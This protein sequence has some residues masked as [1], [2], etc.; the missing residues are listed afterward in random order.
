MSKL[1]IV[2]P[3]F[4]AVG[5]PAQS[6]LNTANALKDAIHISYLVSAQTGYSEDPLNT[7]RQTAKQ[8]ETFKVNSASLRE[9]TL[10]A[11]FALCKLK[12]RSHNFTHVFFFDAH[13]VL[14][15]ALWFLFY[16]LLKP[17]RLSLIYLMG[18][19]RILRSRIATYLVTQ[20]LKRKEVTLY[21]RTEELMVDWRKAF[22]NLAPADIRHLPSLELPAPL[23]PILPPIIG[24]QVKFG[25]L[26]QIRRGKGLEWLVPMFIRR[27]DLG[28][29]LVAG[30]FN[31]ASEAEAMAFLQGFS[32]FR[33]EYLAD[34][35]MLAIAQQQHYLLMLY[36]HWDARMESAVLYLAARA[37]RPVIA[38]GNGWCG[39]Q[40]TEY[41]NGLIAPA[42]HADIESLLQSLP[43]PAS[44]EYT[45]LLL[46]VEK[47][48]Q[49]HSS[50]KLRDLY[51]NE[52]VN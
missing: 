51:L 15:S 25:V 37:G 12:K 9:G 49:A 35:T 39:R 1:I 23:A 36:D 40:I 17:Q 41:G 19:E 52:L 24:D 14:L 27:P 20:F 11:L 6:I 4:T 30:A 10:N 47:F 16:S 33:N 32:G 8:V 43:S 13:L 5:H 29:L 21:L 28:E 7:L 3:W 38:F 34:D 48:R 45:K 50:E 2:Q 18:P 31:N 44:A 46:G 22:T 26:G 42:N